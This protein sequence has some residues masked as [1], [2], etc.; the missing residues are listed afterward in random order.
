MIKKPSIF[1]WYFGLN[2]LIPRYS[3]KSSF[4]LFMIEC[5]SKA[6]GKA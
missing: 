4:F 2:S 3:I 1:I 5:T 6:P